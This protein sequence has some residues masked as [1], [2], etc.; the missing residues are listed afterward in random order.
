MDSSRSCQCVG[1]TLFDE[2]A[3]RGAT[4]RGEDCGLGEEPIGQLDGATEGATVPADQR[5]TARLRPA[6]DGNR[7][8][9]T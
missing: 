3:Q 5:N 2:F 4:P 6:S 8:T 7:P 9:S 1:E